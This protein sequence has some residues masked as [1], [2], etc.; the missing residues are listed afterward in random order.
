LAARIAQEEAKLL[1]AL[2]T[3]PETEWAE[4][5][6]A[7]AAFE[8]RYAEAHLDLFNGH[9]AALREIDTLEEEL[10]RLRRERG[11]LRSAADALHVVAAE[12]GV[13]TEIA[14]LPGQHVAMGKEVLTLETLAPRAARGWVSTTLGGALAPG[15][16][17]SVAFNAE[18]GPQRVQGRVAALEAGID[19]NLSDAFGTLVTIAFPALT[20]DET[21]R[22][23]PHMMPVDVRSQRPWAVAAASRW[24]AL[25]DRIGL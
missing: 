6:A 10:R 2:S 17:V 18:T 14:V 4:A 5:E 1:E 15:M 19:P 7:F 24:Q 16:A 9:R 23:L 20:P 13:V 22:L 8:G 3:L 12:A 21:R 25:R 11:R